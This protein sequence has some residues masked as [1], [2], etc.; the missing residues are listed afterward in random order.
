MPSPLLKRDH[1]VG[2]ATQT[3][4][5][6]SLGSMPSSPPPC[7]I[8]SLCLGLLVC[9]MGMSKGPAS[10][11]YVQIPGA[12]SE[13]KGLACGLIPVSRPG[14]LRI[15]VSFS[16]PPGML[17]PAPH[18]AAVFPSFKTRHKGQLLPR[19]PH[20]KQTALRPH[21]PTPSL[22][23]LCHTYLLHCL[24]LCRDGSSRRA[25]DLSALCTQQ[26]NLDTVCAQQ[27]FVE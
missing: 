24:L 13:N 4:G 6:G 16:P 12:D 9:K 14:Y 27:M 10:R 22:V 23:G 19:P 1:G 20:Y 5:L 25:G 3:P 26:G 21:A 18:A 7:A 15:G 11:A 8:T 17:F 2:A